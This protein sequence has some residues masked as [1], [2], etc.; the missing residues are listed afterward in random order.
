MMRRAAALLV[1]A[2]IMT[3][4]AA[5]AEAQQA[6]RPQ[7]PRAVNPYQ[8]DVN[9]AF[10]LNAITFGETAEPAINAE[11]AR[12][13]TT[14]DVPG[15]AGLSIAA[16]R[17]AWQRLG[18]GVSFDRTSRRS[19][20]GIDASIPHPFVFG[21]NRA[22]EG[23]VDT[24]RDE[25]MVAAQVRYLLPVRRNLAVALFGGPAW[26]SVAQDMV[27]RVDY[28]EA[29]PYDT[30]AFRSAAIERVTGS[31]LGVS[32]GADTAYY[33]SRR[34]GVGLTLQYSTATIGVAS[35]GSSDVES[36][37]GGFNIGAGVRFR[38]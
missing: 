18:V 36:K 10:R 24:S 30:A 5:T 26:F 6:R 37:A 1:T 17:Q 19:A 7:R 34:A 8:I 15:A 4:S 33:L 13:A 2:A 11:Q 22:F 29:Y 20:T 35:L 12:F 31:A 32:I 3:V 21:R 27:Q 14:Y 9:G 38:F 23:A 28:S 25:T 16:S